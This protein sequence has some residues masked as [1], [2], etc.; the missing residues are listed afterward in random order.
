MRRF[1]ETN[2]FKILTLELASL[3]VQLYIHLAHTLSRFLFSALKDNK[4]QV[5]KSVC[6]VP[7]L[8]YKKENVHTCIFLCISCLWKNAE[9][10]NIGCLH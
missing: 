1:Y 7:A 3:I 2:T 5:T 9:N 10:A 4:P 8:A 6:H